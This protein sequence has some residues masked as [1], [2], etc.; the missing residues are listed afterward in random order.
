MQDT[1]TNVTTS[2]TAQGEL[3]RCMVDPALQQFALSVPVRFTAATSKHKDH[4][5]LQQFMQTEV[6]SQLSWFDSTQ[7]QLEHHV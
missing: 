4:R 1:S 3:V 2:F 5:S 6:L 7:Q